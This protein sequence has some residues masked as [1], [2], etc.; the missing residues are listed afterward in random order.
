LY[1][2]ALAACYLPIR[3]RHPTLGRFTS[4]D[5]HAGEAAPPANLRRF[6][7]ADQTPIRA[8]DPV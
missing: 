7:Y 2:P 1:D 6:D 8:A 4:P 5:I 3:C